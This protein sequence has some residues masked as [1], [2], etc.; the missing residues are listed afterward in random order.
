MLSTERINEKMGYESPVS[1]LYPLITEQNFCSVYVDDNDDD[2]N[3]DVDE[4][5]NIDGGEM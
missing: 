3:L 5:G 4:Q 2:D 1:R